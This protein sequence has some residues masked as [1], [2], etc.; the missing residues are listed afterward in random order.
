MSGGGVAVLALAALAMSLARIYRLR[1]RLELAARAE[2]ELR[3]P[4][5]ALAL[6]S[7]AWRRDGAK[8]AIA[9]AV[10]VQ[11]DRMRAA[12]DELERARVG[13]RPRERRRASVDLARFLEASLAP[14]PADNGARSPAVGLP[15]LVADRAGLA[16][17][18]GNLLANAAEHGRG[19]LEVR[20]RR[21]P[22]GVRLELRNAAGDATAT[23]P[24]RG[25]GLRIAEEAA[26]ELGGRLEVRVEDEVLVA[27]LELPAAADARPAPP[28][29]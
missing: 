29:A 11:L 6:A 26:V 25:R 24:G 1:H 27:A 21:S 5:A 2:H 18:L 23:P 7:A 28:A 12:L 10:D 19:P 20:A 8:L 9:D 16:R 3:G 14:W 22:A 13:G 4:A 15:A 17:V